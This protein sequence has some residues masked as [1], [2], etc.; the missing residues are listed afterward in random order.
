MKQGIKGK[1]VKAFALSTS[2]QLAP[3]S[4]ALS[5]TVS[6]GSPV[7]ITAS[8]FYSLISD[9]YSK[10]V[11]IIRENIKRIHSTS[12]RKNTLR[13][14]SLLGTL[15]I[16]K[17]PVANNVYVELPPVFRIFG[18]L[19]PFISR[20]LQVDLYGMFEQLSNLSETKPL[21]DTETKLIKM[22]VMNDVKIL[23][24]NDMPLTYEQQ[25]NIL[26][27]LN[28][29]Y[30]VVYNSLVQ[31][32]K[33]HLPKMIEQSL[34]N[35]FNS[36]IET[37][38]K[39]SC[40]YDKLNDND[41]YHVKVMRKT[42]LAFGIRPVKLS[43]RSVPNSYKGGFFP[44]FVG[45]TSD[46]KC[47]GDDDVEDF[48][49][50]ITIPHDKISS[51]DYEVSLSG[52]PNTA[53]YE[54]AS[55]EPATHH[56]SIKKF[57]DNYNRIVTLE[58]RMYWAKFK[59]AY[60]FLPIYIG[61]RDVHKKKEY[62]QLLVANIECCETRFNTKRVDPRNL[63]CQVDQT[64][65]AESS[66]NEFNGV[67]YYPYILMGVIL[68]TTDE[69]LGSIE[70][71]NF[72]LVNPFVYEKLKVPTGSTDD[73]D[74]NLCPGLVDI[75]KK[76]DDHFFCASKDASDK[77]DCTKSSLSNI[78]SSPSD[79]KCCDMDLYK[80]FKEILTKSN[81]GLLFVS[82]K[83]CLSPIIVNFDQYSS[84]TMS[85]K[86][87]YYEEN[88]DTSPYDGHVIVAGQAVKVLHIRYLTCLIESSVTSIFYVT[89][90][91]C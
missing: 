44:T 5:V 66:Q 33:E 68:D 83:S 54:F 9:L 67:D 28:I 70:D 12:I 23:D 63:Y 3:S 82:N 29:F 57:L 73:G 21:S 27:Y 25:I 13:I 38:F 64:Y 56:L 48:I 17:V 74:H 91:Q 76:F 26:V 40:L 39:L 72:T 53:K 45:T 71:I 35:H 20:I 85:E 14:R 24:L 43:L 58:N 62:E 84:A 34:L 89:D 36:I 80:D 55:I 11:N 79:L 90:I 31:I 37:R 69:T 46:G 7:D 1:S 75:L 65:G 32:S 6:P 78:L 4:S 30:H 10:Y 18:L 2:K 86:N 61:R 41:P 50:S 51:S 22:S 77:Y 59:R 81:V 8:S 19:L 88:D 16:D 87:E 52:T 47:I 49:D 60:G 42:M 15:S